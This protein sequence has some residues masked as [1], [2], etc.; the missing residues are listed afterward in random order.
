[1]QDK[2]QGLIIKAKAKKEGQEPKKKEEDDDAGSQSDR[3]SVENSPLSSLNKIKS[4]LGNWKNNK[5]DH[6]NNRS[7]PNLLKEAELADLNTLFK[8][9]SGQLDRFESHI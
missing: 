6:S 2:L 9:F 3:D 8:K 5:K 4:Q 1:M 7:G